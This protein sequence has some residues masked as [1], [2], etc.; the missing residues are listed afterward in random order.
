MPSV[1]ETIAVVGACSPERH[2]Y[3]ETL[4]RRTHR[5][6]FPA[7]R[8]S[9]SPDPLDEA[10]AVV[11][12]AGDRG[13]VVEYPTMCLAS[14]IIASLYRERP[15]VRLTALICVVD[16]SHILRD[17]SDDGYLRRPRALSEDTDNAAIIAR[18]TVTVTHIELATMIVIVNWEKMPTARLSLTMALLSHL[19]PVAKLRLFRT[20]DEPWERYAAPLSD[21]PLAPERDSPGWVRILNGEYSPY[22]EDPHVTSIRYEQILPFH[23]ERLESALDRIDNAEFGTVIRSAGFC[24]LATRQRHAALWDHTGHMISFEPLPSDGIEAAAQTG[25][26]CPSLGEDIAFIGLDLL[27]RELARALDSALL[28]PAELDAGPMVWAIFTDPFPAWSTA[29]FTD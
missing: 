16:A 24:R 2:H 12:W 15:L 14:E 28:T 25:D 17:L 4:A 10:A 8:L 9:A 19:N 29:D 7:I 20:D 22:M 1:V 23:P 18:A 6:F 3:A 11:P 21:A 26:A 13:A 5:E 27:P